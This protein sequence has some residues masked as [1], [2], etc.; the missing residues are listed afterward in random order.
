LVPSGLT[1]ACDLHHQFLF[2]LREEP[3]PPLDEEQTCLQRGHN[4][5]AVQP[6]ADNPMQHS[7]EVGELIC[8]IFKINNPNNSNNH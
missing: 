4:R 1:L 3:W 7:G 5:S 8:H 6:L 2:I